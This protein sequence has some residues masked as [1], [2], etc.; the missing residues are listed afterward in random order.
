MDGEGRVRAV[1]AVLGPVLTERMGGLVG[2]AE[3]HALGHGGVVLVARATGLS[4][5]TIGQGLRERAEPPS[6]APCQ[7]RQRRPGGGRK[8]LTAH[9]PTLLGDL[10]ALVEPVTRGDPQAPL[11]WTCKSLRQRA[12]ALQA[13]GHQVSG[14]QVGDLLRDLDGSLQ[15]THKTT[16][17]ATRPDRNAQFAHINAQAAA[18]QERGQPVISVDAKKKELVGDFKNG[19]RER[20]P[21]GQPEEVRVYGFP[22]KALGKL[23]PYGVYDIGAHQGW[24]SAG[25]DHDTAAFAVE[26]VRRWW[27]QMGALTYPEATESLITADGGG[28]NSS[29]SRPRKVALQ[30]L[31]DDTG[32]RVAACHLPPAT[33]KRNKIAHRMFSRI[34][35][36]WR[37]RPLV[38]HDVVVNLV[39]STTTR[40]GLH[41][42]AAPDRS[43]YP[44]KQQVSDDD[45]AAVH[46]HR[47]AFHGEWNYTILPTHPAN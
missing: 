23:T 46:L 7:R 40:T 13:Q 24:V 31:A 33:S 25:T 14:R 42:R 3:A 16:E 44:T 20:Q 43:S 19:G 8:P 38:S 4:R 41:I 34:T 1:F 35:E 17:G 6:E 27:Q 12:A 32:L 47:D 26:T 5:A 37:G 9:D 29:R 15:G 30:H 28:S 36:N 22:D 39:G 18:F 2:A 10:E 11:R 21:A 45:L